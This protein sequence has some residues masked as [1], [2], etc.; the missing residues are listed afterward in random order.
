MSQYPFEVG[1]QYRNRKGNYT[2][3]EIMGEK[4]RIRYEDGVENTV[5]TEFQARFWA[6]IQAEEAPPLPSKDDS[7]ET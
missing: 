3:L 5:K 1:G 7:L 4:M 6:N 2:V